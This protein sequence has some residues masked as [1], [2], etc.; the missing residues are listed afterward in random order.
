[1][2]L[3]FAIQVGAWMALAMLCN[4]VGHLIEEAPPYDRF[5]EGVR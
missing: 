5:D 4:Y 2:T 3:I 1:M